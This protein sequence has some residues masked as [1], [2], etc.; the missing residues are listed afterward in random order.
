MSG[1]E[2]L[3]A[4]LAEAKAA[5]DHCEA[6][7]GDRTT[8]TSGSPSSDA[9]GPASG[10]T[11]VDDE[12][13]K[14][15]G[16][17]SQATILVDLALGAGVELFHTPAGDSYVSIRT[18]SH[19]EQHR[20]NSRGARDYLVR[21]FYRD[22]GKAPNASALQDAIATL[23]GIAK[24]DGKEHEVHVRVAGDDHRVYLDLGDPA[25]QAVEITAAGWRVVQEPS[26]R[27]R[28]PRGMLALPM[29]VTGGSVDDLRP[30]VN[31]AEDDFPLVAAWQTAALR[32]RGPY[33]LLDL[34][35]EQGSAKSTSARVIRRTIDPHES[36]LR[37]PPRN[38]EDVMI[39]AANSYVVT[40][41][42][43]S[44][45]PDWLSD[46]LAVL[47]TGGGLSKRELYSDSEECILRAQR[48]IIINGI[49][50]V[51]T[52]G[53]LLDRAIVVTLPVIPDDQRR[54]EADF[55]SAFHK[56]HPRILGA[57]LDGVSMALRNLPTVTVE[58]L[59]R[60]A[61]FTLW[62]VAAEP[63]YP[64]EPGTFLSTYLGN[65]QSAVE[66]GLDGDPVVDAVRILAPWEGTATELLAEVTKRTPE[67]I[68]KRKDWF[69]KPRQVS[70]ALRRLAPGLRRVGIEVV[71]HRHGHGRT[72]LIGITR[73]AASASSA[74]S[75][76]PDSQGKT[77][78]AAADAAS[79]SSARPSASSADST[80]V[81]GGADAADAADAP[82]P[83]SSE[84]KDDDADYYGA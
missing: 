3:A 25:W 37:R 13:D 49:G 36:E 16:K 20:L 32:P 34:L 15:P 2:T 4:Q 33:V 46:D 26:L 82:Q 63:A 54:H 39:A 75:V 42:N 41:D 8:D 35:G 27:F 45:L 80:N 61:D 71:F 28:R 22:S 74:S 51:V 6:G 7:D 60:M 18:N 24:F 52:R 84:P 21:L 66:A 67:N 17:K 81:S 83:F 64:W 59:P 68:T 76:R 30:F 43:V 10:P 9:T 79:A 72:R 56:A 1:T 31:V 55:W 5:R 77:A 44:Y 53:D 73:I 50:Q 40:V 65:R 23:H 70:D 78:D 62:N 69:S 14:A 19:R 58:R 57:L 12:T 38:T 11:T 29:P 47:A 48:P